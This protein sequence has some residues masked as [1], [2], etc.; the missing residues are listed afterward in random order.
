MQQRSMS[1]FVSPQANVSI[2]GAVSSIVREKDRKREK[3]RIRGLYISIGV[4]AERVV[5]PLLV[6]LLS[7]WSSM[8][9]CR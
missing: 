8:R 6:L 5:L 2:L 3:R 7:E 4:V 1:V 9:R